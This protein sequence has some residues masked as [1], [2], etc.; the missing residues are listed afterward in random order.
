MTQT[1]EIDINRYNGTDYDTLLPTP[2]THAATHKADGTDPIVCQTGN[3]GDKTVT[4]AKIADATVSATQLASNAVETVK[5]KDANVTRAKLANDALITPIVTLPA[6]YTLASADVGKTLRFSNGNQ[7]FVL[8]VVKDAQ[9]P[10]GATY[11]IFRYAAKSN[12]IVFGNTVRV[13]FMGNSNYV[14]GPTFTISEAFGQI[15][16][17]KFASD[18]DYDYWHVTGPAEVV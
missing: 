7:D 8:N 15:A 2:A 16:I 3:Y 11:A 6:S 9:I 13:T 12:K 4:G 1:Y 18:N 14:A 10:I 17:M 5:I